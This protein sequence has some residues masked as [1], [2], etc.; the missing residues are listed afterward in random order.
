MLFQRKTRVLFVCTANICRSPMAEGILR[1]E[2]EQRGLQRKIRV[3][4]AGTH[5]SQPGRSADPRAQKVCGREGIDLGKC[6]ARQIKE[7]DFERFDH[8]LAMDEK[9]Y[10]WLFKS[11]PENYRDR[12]SLLCPWAKDGSAIDIPDPYYG[13]FAGFEKVLSMLHDSIN[14]FVEHIAH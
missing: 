2:L 5:A 8:I 3:D 1:L 9:N 14:G 11:C 4:S 6:R 13:N 7:Q 12:I 10:Q